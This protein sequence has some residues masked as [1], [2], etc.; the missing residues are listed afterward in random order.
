MNCTSVVPIVKCVEM[1]I[2]HVQRSRCCANLEDVLAVEQRLVGW[3][4]RT[5]HLHQCVNFSRLRRVLPIVL[6]QLSPI[7][8]Q[9][10]HIWLPLST[11]CISR[12]AVHSLNDL[13]IREQND[14]RGLY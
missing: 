6:K 13:A 4:H 9:H 2:Q 11:F 8:I 5:V 3:L 14:G 7:S 12:S 1:H 10:K